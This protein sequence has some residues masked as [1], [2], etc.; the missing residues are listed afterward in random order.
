MK[1]KQI[2]RTAPELYLVTYQTRWLK[3]EVERWVISEKWE[4]DGEPSEYEFHFRDTG[5]LL[6]SLDGH[7]TL[8]WMIRNDVDFFDNAERPAPPPPKILTDALWRGM[9]CDAD[10]DTGP[11][12]D[13]KPIVYTAE[14]IASSCRGS[15]SAEYYEI[16]LEAAIKA[17]QNG[18]LERDME[19]QT[20]N[21]S[22]KYYLSFQGTANFNNLVTAFDNIPP[23]TPTEPT[24]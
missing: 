5:A 22:V 9:P 4:T 24:P 19:L 18:R 20:L 11:E 23:L 21:E 12:P 17:N 8:E 15:A 14:G 2:R 3:R 16:A 1:I 13:E 10:I 6:F 7:D